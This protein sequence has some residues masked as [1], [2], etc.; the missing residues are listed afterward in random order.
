M[1]EDF[2]TIVLDAGHGDQDSGAVGPTGLL[3]KDVAL[4][5]VML[6]GAILTP[7]VRVI[8]TRRDDTF[9][10]LS[11]RATIANDAQAFLFL[12]VHCN[13]GPPG[14]GDGIEIFT[15][16][17][18]TDSDA[19][20]TDIF[21]AYS[22]K[23]PNKRRR[24]DLGDG[25]PDKEAKFTVLTK[26]HMR[27]ALLELE[28][29]HTQVGENWLRDKRNHQLAAQA[30]ADGIL[31]H[32]NRAGEIYPPPVAT[33]VQVD[34][35]PLEIELLAKIERIRTRFAEELQ[36]VRTEVEALFRSVP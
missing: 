23:V 11:R 19:F 36:E 27:A 29:I 4:S 6:A 22:A 18:Q 28:F 15:S 13:S 14:Q 24:M 12:S 10:E 33:P 7:Y 16:P 3:E 8:Y 32:L 17:G 1:N 21:E 31:R 9:I 25:D 2:V 20:A 34:R 35:K 30:I 26:T 5:V